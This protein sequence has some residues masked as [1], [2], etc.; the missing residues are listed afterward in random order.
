MVPFC[1]N[2]LTYKEL[3]N[4]DLSEALTQNVVLGIGRIASRTNLSL[5]YQ[6][7][8]TLCIMHWSHA[9]FGPKVAKDLVSSL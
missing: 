8:C 2:Q 1:D 5:P 3:Y 9:H 4:S 7:W 6:G